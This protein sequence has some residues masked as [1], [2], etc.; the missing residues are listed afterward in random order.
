MRKIILFLFMVSSLSIS[1][2]AQNE[3]AVIEEQMKI[4]KNYMTPGIMHEMMAKNTGDWDIV[5]KFWMDPNSTEASVSNAVGTGQMILGGRY[6]KMTYEGDV[7]GMPMEGFSLEGFDNG[8][9]EFQNIW[10]D[11][12][13]TGMAYSTGKYDAANKKVDYIGTMYDAMGGMDTEFRS[14]M[15]FND[16]GTMVFSMYGKVEGNEYLMM[17]QT[18]TKKK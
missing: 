8:K 7:M 10:I 11:N 14:V 9:Q 17:E 4:W 6:L 15:K 12:M 3:N 18:Y 1:S 5:S 13:G 2:F 16:D